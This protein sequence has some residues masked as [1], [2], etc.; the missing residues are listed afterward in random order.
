MI[1]HNITRER[2]DYLI[3]Q[4]LM[5]GE[6]NTFFRDKRNALML[7]GVKVQNPPSDQM[8]AR[9]LL[10]RFST[11]AHR[12][13]GTWIQQLPEEESDVAPDQW[14]PRYRAIEQFGVRFSPEETRI[15]ARAGLKELYRENPREDWIQFL[16]TPPLQHSTTTLALGAEMTLPRDGEWVAFGRWLCGSG[17]LDELV[18]PV[19]R[20]AAAIVAEWDRR[21]PSVDITTNEGKR[22]LPVI[23]KIIKEGDRVTTTMPM[24]KGLRAGAPP[25]R[26]KEEDVDYLA[27]PVIATRVH[28][29]HSGPYMARVEAFVD[30][31]GAF[32]LEEPE[33]REAVKTLGRVAIFPD[34]GFAPPPPGEAVMYRVEAHVTTLP[35]Q[36]RAKEVLDTALIPVVRLPYGIKEAHEIRKGIEQYARNTHARPAVFVTAD[37]L[38]LKPKVD[39]LTQ[40]FARDFDWVLDTWECLDGVEF[41]SGTYVLAPLPPPTGKLSCAP[42]AAAASKLLRDAQRRAQVNLT[43]TQVAQLQEIIRSDGL[44]V[45][46]LSRNRLEMNV[47]SIGEAGEDYDDLVNLLIEAPVV[48]AD[49][50]RRVASRVDELVTERHREIG[51]IDGL[52]SQREIMEAK[53]KELKSEAR[54]KTKAV[55]TAVA[56]AFEKATAKE[57]EALGESSVLLALIGHNAQGNMRSE[58]APVRVGA[59]L[60]VVEEST[61]SRTVPIRRVESER[62][63]TSD[64]FRRFGVSAETSERVSRVLRVAVSLSLPI[65]TG[66]SGARPLAKRLAVALS[67]DGFFVCD[68]PIGLVGNVQLISRFGSGDGVG[69]LLLDAN[70]SD[71]SVY[72]PDVLDEVV[73]RA[74]GKKGTLSG[75][76]L[77]LSLSSGLAG[78]PLPAELNELA[79]HLDLNVLS[80]SFGSNERAELRPQGILA[81]RALKRLDSD[82]E[83]ANLDVVPAVVDDLMWLL[84]Q[85][86]S[87]S[88]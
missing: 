53:L 65:V 10:H 26:A 5:A 56:R 2:F 80:G 4:G 54:E 86:A 49:I 1:P 83:L 11:E 23:E 41:S 17:S 62:G 8:A 42:L 16:S 36:V 47:R 39:A 66:G 18:S 15:V 87:A 61:A 64:V 44:G 79:V 84:C 72:A 19:L 21:V 75:R 3:A 40:L 74:I 25:T 76:P 37:D 52:R 57:I 14:I 31:S 29:P 22:A 73:T 68:I 60:P 48:K 69:I 30:E 51:A 55:R 58:I 70:L 20:D 13:F 85:R 34:R 77:M 88:R 71:I 50:E 9:A 63:E 82:V 27:L 81:E 38:C 67:T 28:S 32:R 46:D 24:R 59:E 45:D 78:L 43:K 35:V 12:V 6:L 33:L 7:C